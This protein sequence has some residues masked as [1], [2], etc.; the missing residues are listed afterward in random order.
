MT[1]RSACDAP[2]LQRNVLTS[3]LPLVR[4]LGGRAALLPPDFLAPFLRIL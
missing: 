1:C 4:T 2:Q 3:P